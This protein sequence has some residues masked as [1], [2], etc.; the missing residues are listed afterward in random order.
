[1]KTAV[2]WLVEEINKLT[3]LTIQMDEPIIEQAKEMEKKQIKKAWADGNYNTDSNG[4][5]SENYVISDNS[6]YQ[7]TFKSE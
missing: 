2:E 5:P 4:N 1:M 6:Y 7:K 3:G